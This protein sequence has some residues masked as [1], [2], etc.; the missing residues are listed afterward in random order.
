MVRVGSLPVRVEK[1]EKVEIGV[2]VPPLGGEREASV[3]IVTIP[4][5]EISAED[6]RDRVETR[7][8]LGLEDGRTLTEALLLKVKQEESVPKGGVRLLVGVDEG[9]VER[10]NEGVLDV[11]EQ[12]EE[13]RVK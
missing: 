4:L 6:V 5:G 11:E 2:Y 12:C 10:H 13:V 9:V 7:V 1:G 8:K 3:D